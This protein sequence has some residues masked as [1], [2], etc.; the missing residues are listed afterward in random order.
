[1]LL[2]LIVIPPGIGSGGTG[3]STDAYEE[4]PVG[5]VN[6]IN[7]DYILLNEA[8]SK[9]WIFVFVNGVS[10]TDFTYNNNTSISLLLLIIQNSKTLLLLLSRIKGS[11]PISNNFLKA[12]VLLNKTA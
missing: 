6:G 3:T 9:E 5:L 10:R 2:N 4:V 1:M 8:I 12:Y 11:A 7:K